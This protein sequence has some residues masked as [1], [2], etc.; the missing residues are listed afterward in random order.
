MDVYQ[1]MALTS[2]TDITVPIM[3]PTPTQSQSPTAQQ[4]DH[5][6]PDPAAQMS[7]QNTYSASV[8]DRLSS[9]I[10][11]SYPPAL[12]TS[13]LTREDIRQRAQ[14]LAAKH[15]LNSKK[16]F[17]AWLEEEVVR[18]EGELL[19]RAKR[20]QDALAHNR[21]VDEELRALEEQYAVEKRVLGR[22]IEDMKK[23]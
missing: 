22:K 9:D 23:R 18:L 10:L 1:S 8:E 11:A 12:D 14:V 21:S 19:A 2:R 4:H 16:G 6:N 3:T 5:D 20:R 17:K 15:G 7:Q 13:S